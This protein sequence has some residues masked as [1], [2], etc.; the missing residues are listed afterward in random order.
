MARFSIPSVTVRHSWLTVLMLM[1]AFVL[2]STGQEPANADAVL[3]R[4]R[5]RLLTEL[6]RMPRY[7]CLQMI[8]RQYFRPPANK[9]APATLMLDDQKNQTGKLVL[10]SWDR[11]RL[12]V[13]VL[14][15]KNAYSWVD[16]PRFGGHTLEQFAE[17]G[18]LTSGD[19]GPFLTSI[20]ESA[21]II[22][23]S[24][25]LASQKRLPAGLHFRVRIV[26]P[27]DSDTVAVGDAIE[28][29]LLSPIRGNNGRELAP[30][31][32]RLHGRLLGLMQLKGNTDVIEVVMQLQS[33]GLMGVTY[34]YWHLRI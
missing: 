17:G 13:A 15:G 1:L 5:E 22:F 7:T 30:A 29:V 18:P 32:A 11:V 6:A 28:A 8:N 27:I 21:T 23:K 9:R 25:E 14:E 34:R 2:V 16:A 33:I 24:Q 31:G 19:F 20:F 12:E 4:T 10:R 26:T 3:R